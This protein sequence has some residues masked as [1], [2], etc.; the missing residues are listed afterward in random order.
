MGDNWYG[1]VEDDAGG[2][3]RISLLNMDLSERFSTTDIQR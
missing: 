3:E 1:V 2:T